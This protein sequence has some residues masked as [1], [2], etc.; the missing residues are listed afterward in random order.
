MKREQIENSVWR[1]YF[2]SNNAVR[3]GVFPGVESKVEKIHPGKFQVVKTEYSENGE[4][5]S[6]QVKLIKE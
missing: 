2:R 4:V 5:L 1:N 3:N 6:V